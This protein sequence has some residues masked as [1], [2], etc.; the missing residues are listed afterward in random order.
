MGTVDALYALSWTAD[1][2]AAGSLILTAEYAEERGLR[3]L[4]PP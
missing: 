3:D 1:V 4:I 2:P